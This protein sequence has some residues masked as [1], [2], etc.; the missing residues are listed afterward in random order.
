MYISHQLRAPL[1]TLFPQ[2]TLRDCTACGI[3]ESEV[4]PKRL[5]LSLSSSLSLSLSLIQ[6]HI[7]KQFGGGALQRTSM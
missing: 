3:C 4:I 5:S 2:L 6:T 1:N 7:Q